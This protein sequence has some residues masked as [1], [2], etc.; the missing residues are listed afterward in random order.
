ML[1]ISNVLGELKA[2]QT[3]FV[4]TIIHLRN[5]FGQHLQVK[6]K[7]PGQQMFTTDCAD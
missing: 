5:P 4:R 2:D 1:V 7:L 3:L 6:P